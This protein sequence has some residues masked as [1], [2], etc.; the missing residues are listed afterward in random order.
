M[1]DVAVPINYSALTLS[2]GEGEAN[3]P[4]AE[5]CRV[6][7]FGPAKTRKT[8][9]A[10]TAAAAGFNL[11]I[12]D[13]E[14]G[15]GILKQ[16]PKSALPNIQRVAV[17]QST[18]GSTMAAFLMLML[19]HQEFVYCPRTRKKMALGGL[20]DEQQYYVVDLNLFTQSDVL[21]IDSWTQIIRDITEDF[22]DLNNLDV[23][24][25]KIA[26]TSSSGK[27][28]KFAYFNYCNLVLDTIVSRL[29]GLPCHVIMTAHR[30]FYTHEVREGASKRDE[31]HVQVLSTSGNQAAKVPAAF[32]DVIYFELANDGMHSTLST[33]GSKTRISGGRRVAPKEEKFPA[34]DF[35]AYAKEADLPP[36]TTR[37]ANSRPPICLLTGL[38]IKSLA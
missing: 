26:A 13:G 17:N 8:W 9:W 12:I 33:K 20:K 28:D 7:C 35:A 37:D 36:P 19:E 6:L 38:Q 30:D 1:T 2:F 18:T 3:N 24:E 32:G 21:L 27:E 15:T 4:Q 5:P 14:N 23:F 22:K 10:G 34:W 31:T 11:T 25:G 29:N 16:L